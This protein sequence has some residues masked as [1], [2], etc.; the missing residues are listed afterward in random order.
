MQVQSVLAL[1]YDRVVANRLIAWAKISHEQAA[2]QEGE[3]TLSHVTP[4]DSIDKEIYENL[5]RWILFLM[6]SHYV[7]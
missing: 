4:S 6:Y 7:F 1:I 2:F 5:I 3:G